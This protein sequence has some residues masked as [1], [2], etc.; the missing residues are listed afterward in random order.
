MALESKVCFVYPDRVPTRSPRRS[1]TSD[2][3]PGVTLS[4]FTE[5][6]GRGQRHGEPGQVGVEAAVALVLRLQRAQG[7]SGEVQLVRDPWG[8]TPLE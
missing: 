7:P 5:T 6:H 3:L 8:Y 2:Q 1:Q 4:Q